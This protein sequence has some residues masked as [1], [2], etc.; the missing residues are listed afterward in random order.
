M[1]KNLFFLGLCAL[2]LSSCHIGD[3]KINGGSQI[4]PSAN[5]VKKEYPMSDFDKI[6]VDVIANVKYIQTNDRPR[7]V[8]S[9]PDNYIELFE[10]DVESH[11]LSLEFCR[12]NVNIDAENVDITIYSSTLRGLENDGLAN[13]E[14]SRL[15]TDR[16]DVENSGV[17]SMFL[18]GLTVGELEAECSGVG[19]IE[20]SGTAKK[21][22]LDCS[23]VGSIK[24]QGL[25]ANEV[26]G[27][28]SGVGSIHCYAVDYIDAEVSGVGSLQY[29]GNPE[30]KELRRT[31]VG[32]ISPM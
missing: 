17:G 30:R 12:S 3:I 8:L 23:G 16:L 18:S 20:L 10:F 26:K 22:T 4:E 31:G 15:K 21:A 1:K 9:A 24:A 19:N 13:I 11:K 14:I 7:V 6:D 27:D 29:G 28:V 32:N 5:I 25:K 2:L